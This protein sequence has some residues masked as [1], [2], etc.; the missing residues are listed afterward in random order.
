MTSIVTERLL[1]DDNV[2]STTSSVTNYYLS[3]MW[4]HTTVLAPDDENVSLFDLK[5]SS[6][7]QTTEMLTD[8]VIYSTA[9]GGPPQLIDTWGR[10]S[11]SLLIEVVLA[12]TVLSCA[13]VICLICIVIRFRREKVNCNKCV[14]FLFCF[15]NNVFLCLW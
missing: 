9:M 15:N 3:H 12:L 6:L 10:R 11:T 8:D 1:D 7:F 13:V 5:H 14:S 4:T 2:Q